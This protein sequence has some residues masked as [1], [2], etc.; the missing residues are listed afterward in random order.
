[1]SWTGSGLK[2][3]VH[4]PNPNIEPEISEMSGVL[5]GLIAFPA[6]IRKFYE[7]STKL[8]YFISVNVCDK[9]QTNV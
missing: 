1:M 5:S 6:V 9:S 7:V 3:T 4:H 2:R 8:E